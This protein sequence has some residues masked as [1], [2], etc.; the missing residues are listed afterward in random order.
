MCVKLITRKTG[1]DQGES[2]KKIRLAC[3]PWMQPG[4]FY[5]REKRI[6]VDRWMDVV[7]YISMLLYI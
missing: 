4:S 2:E 7:L 1:H 3:V 5:V 6:S